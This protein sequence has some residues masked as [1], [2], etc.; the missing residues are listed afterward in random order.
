MKKIIQ[1]LKQFK[2]SKQ[3]KHERLGA[4]NWIDGLKLNGFSIS[5]MN[6]DDNLGSN[7]DHRMDMGK[8]IESKMFGGIIV[9][10][11]DEYPSGLTDSPIIN[12]IKN[13]F[14]EFTIGDFVNGVY[15]FSD[16]S[17]FKKGSISIEV[18]N[19]QTNQLFALTE[20]ILNETS[21]ECAL[22]KVYSE[23]EIYVVRGNIS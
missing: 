4:N 11:A 12:H 21:K 14:V 2:S 1:F 22:V 3:P 17:T 15:R 8:S 7:S 18:V 13:K 5:K 20:Q 16:V 9:F 19:I 10:P 23:N 6:I